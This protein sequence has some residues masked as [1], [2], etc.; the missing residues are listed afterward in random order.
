V[1]RLSV[2]LVPRSIESLEGELRMLGQQFPAVD[3]VNIP[4]LLRFP[5]RSWDA[6]RVARRL[7]RHAI[8][9]LRAMDFA[10][11]KP[12]P[13]L[14]GFAEAGIDTVLVVA[15]D[16]PQSP[17]HPVYQVRPV[18]WIRRLKRE[19]PDLRVYAAFDPYRAGMHAELES[20]RAKLDAGAD[21][22]FSQPFFDVRLLDVWAEQLVGCDVW[23]GF[24]PV[25]STST[26]R[27]W[28][29]KNQAVFPAGFAPTLDWNRRFAEA[30]LRWVR[31]RDADAYFMPIRVGVA[32]WLGGLL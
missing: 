21:G 31:A 25:L 32:D 10:P 17:G 2:E 14:D 7:V 3:T 20:V 11:E 27:Y 16:P 29:T 28:E 12:F 5:V 13:L 18:D 22:F 15:G 1:S 4:D 24:S 30:A 6:C 26:R 19:A 8:P 23:W 9:H